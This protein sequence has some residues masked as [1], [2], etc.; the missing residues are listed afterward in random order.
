MNC[1]H[2]PSW[3]FGLEQGRCVSLYLR[4]SVVLVF[5]WCLYVVLFVYQRASY[6]LCNVLA[7]ERNAQFYSYLV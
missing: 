7:L 5:V 4:E 2:R 3:E 1:Y 6:Y